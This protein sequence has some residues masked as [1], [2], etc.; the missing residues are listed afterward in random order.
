MKGLRRYAIS[1]LALLFCLVPY[2]WATNETT[3]ARQLWQL[4][5]YIGVDYTGAVQDGAVINALEYAEMQ[6]FA[7]SALQLAISMP[8]SSHHHDLVAAVTEVKRRVDHQLPAAQVR[9][10]VLKAS[11]QLLTAFEIVVP[12]ATPPSLAKGEALYRANC[13]QC[14]GA[15]GRGDGPLAL[16]LE[17]RPVAFTDR[18]RS[19]GRSVFALYQV[20]SLGVE[21]TAMP[22][23][24]ALSDDE[25]WALA[26]FIGGL[27]Y[28]NDMRARGK[29]GWH[30]DN[31]SRSLIPDL[32][33]LVSASETS[34]SDLLQKGSARDLLAYL[35][36]H[37]DAL[38]RTHRAQLQMARE[39]LQESLAAAHASNWPEATNKALS[40]YL[41][42]FEPLE[43]LLRARAPAQL[44]TVEELML[45]YRASLQQQDRAQ[46]ARI[47]NELNSTF[48]L[49]EQT[50]QTS[51][52]SPTTTFIGALTILL[53]EGFEAL[54]I[55]VGMIVFLQKS[56]SRTLL[57]YVH[58]GWIGALIAGGLTWFIATYA[59]SIS[60]A[61]REVTEGLS[62]LFAAIVLLVV[63]IWM[64][65][66]SA[67][68]Q[69]QHYLQRTLS[70]ALMR[71]SAWAAFALA[72]VAVYREVFETV[73]FYSALVA[74][75]NHGAL[76]AGLSVGI[77]LLC[78]VTWVLLRTGARL[79]I[80]TFFS[81]S[82]LIVALLAIVLAGKG[83]AGLQEAGWIN[84][85]PA[86]WPS[87]DVLGMYPS[88]ETRLAQLIVLAVTSLGFVVNSISARRTIEKN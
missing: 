59:I 71:Q 79:P 77:V 45:S 84:A 72:F 56:A 64:H 17:P 12:P 20:I 50:L 7:D 16:Q 42:G 69:W 32:A 9:D 34:L 70:A 41:D 62:S 43:P 25:R 30:N 52:T 76:I 23:F 4:L 21:G 54:L 19:A 40:A 85:N 37:P 8:A 74:E 83:I 35:R 49:I 63:G 75:G 15:T 39:R 60:G 58:G 68:G 27:S 57:P 33:T 36:Q 28:D 88:R 14:H 47:A 51:V 5:D 11:Q 26:F 82:S 22:A 87:I 78:I 53:R 2:A 48:G 86:M 3:A 44:K 65:Q 1:V 13:S 24:S 18:E 29:E 66:K 67:A 55:V 10:S 46:A 31:S 73:L 80:G 6:Q 61:N 81:V 38:G